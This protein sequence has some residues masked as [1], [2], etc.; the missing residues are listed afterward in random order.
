MLP[1]DWAI[2]L[3][4]HLVERKHEGRVLE[5]FL[6]C[7]E[8]S[9]FEDKQMLR[10]IIE[11]KDALLS[12]SWTDNVNKANAQS[13]AKNAADRIAKEHYPWFEN[14]RYALFW[15]TA[16]N[17]PQPAM[18]ACLDSTNWLQVAQE[19]FANELRARVPDCLF[20]WIYGE[21]QQA[22]VGR[23]TNGRIYE[24]LRWRKDDSG[25]N[26]WQYSDRTLREISMVKT[27]EKVLG[28]SSSPVLRDA[29]GVAL[30]VADDPAKGGTIIFASEDRVP[31]FRPMGD[32]LVPKGDLSNEDLI[33]LIAQDGASLRAIPKLGQVGRRWQHR[34]L[35]TPDKDA[36]AW[37]T[38]LQ[39][40]ARKQ[41]QPWPL[42]FK[43]SRR[44][45]AAMTAFHE[46]VN[47]VLVISQDGDIQI[48]HVD[49]TDLAKTI[50]KMWELPLHGGL[51]VNAPPFQVELP[52]S[53][54]RSSQNA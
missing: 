29:V 10:P 4:E 34:R 26:C 22:G 42:Q 53:L 54:P 14:G 51:D 9:E 30:S 45:S 7:G 12:L 21:P 47:A 15:D 3:A 39:E 37:L 43:G 41:Q 2:L 19:R 11:P 13:V 25:T 40:A 50:V 33:A 35:L 6:V 36:D 44:W 31:A 32:P 38:A 18:L 52:R 16:T 48:W 27:L 23:V 17:S 5:F 46:D 20:C 1:T 8:R 49:R 24:L 28:I